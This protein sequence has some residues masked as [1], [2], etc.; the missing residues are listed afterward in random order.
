[1]Q[2]KIALVI[3]GPAGEMGRPSMESST[4]LRELV[5]SCRE[6]FRL[7]EGDYQLLHKS[8]PLDS[9]LTL[10]EAGVAEGDR[11]QL[12]P[13]REP[14]HRLASEL[15]PEPLLPQPSYAEVTAQ[16]VEAAA[17]RRRSGPDPAGYQ[18]GTRVT[19]K[20]F[21]PG[22]VVAREPKGKLWKLTIHFEGS[23]GSRDILSCFV[24]PLE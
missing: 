19:H 24:E 7:G 14:A 5:E 6:R 17:L 20:L 21:G 10:A 12:A 4:P 22:T 18:E 16:K 11:L 23:A 13:A 1:M 9:A 15:K 2:S 8:R 3:E